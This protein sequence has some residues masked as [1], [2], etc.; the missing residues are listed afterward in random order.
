[1]KLA[2]LRR[3]DRDGRLV[4]VNRAEPAAYLFQVPNGYTVNERK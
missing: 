4:N 1:M 3:G 2:T